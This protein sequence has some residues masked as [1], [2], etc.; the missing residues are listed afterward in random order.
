MI[1]LHGAARDHGGEPSAVI[2][3]ARAILLEKLAHHFDFVGV[4]GT[5][6]PFAGRFD[7]SRR[8]AERKEIAEFDENVELKYYEDSLKEFR[9]SES[10]A[11]KLNDK[12]CSF[13]CVPI[14]FFNSDK[15]WG[16][17]SVDSMTRGGLEGIDAR[18]LEGALAHYSTF[19]Q[20]E[21][22]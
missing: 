22:A 10:K 20:T 13:L 21:D 2:A 15:P 3:F 19:F 18:R 7:A 1:G 4:D 11:R 5:L 17:L 12:A 16:I 6:S 8:K 14:L 9:L